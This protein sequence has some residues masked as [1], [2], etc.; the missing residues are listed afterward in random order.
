MYNLQYVRSLVVQ[1][2]P[3]GYLSK[4]RKTATT[5]KHNATYALFMYWI[6]Q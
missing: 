6:L 5:T 3:F 2:I 1:F 4:D